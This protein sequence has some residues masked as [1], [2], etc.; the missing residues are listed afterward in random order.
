MAETSKT[1]AKASSSS[2]V[3]PKPPPFRLQALSEADQYWKILIYGA[4]GMGK[5]LLAGTCVDVEFMRN[6]F[7]IS[8]EKG[9]LSI[10]ESET[11]EHKDDLFIAIPNTVADVSKMKDWLVAHCRYRDEGNNEMLVKIQKTIGIDSDEPR[12]FNTCIIDSVSEVQAFSIYQAKG[13]SANIALDADL[14]KTEWDHYNQ[15]LDRIQILMRAFRDLPIH[16]IFLC[17]EQWVQDESKKFNF[18][19]ALQG[20]M[21]RRVQGFVDVVGYLCQ[22]EDSD[23]KSVRRV[24]VQPVGKFAAKNRKGSF[25]GSHFDNPTI[26]MIMEAFGKRV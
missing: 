12:I 14:M 4:H 2:S 16:V 3:K 17:Q 13:Y 22:R 25:K 6:V 15:I 10:K 9:H 1:S 20:Q 8:A 7:M 21:S 19:P 26:P 5:T 11:I 24:F 18:A 23:G